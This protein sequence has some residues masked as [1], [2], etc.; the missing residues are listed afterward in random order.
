MT[1]ALPRNVRPPAAVIATV[2]TA[3]TAILSSTAVAATPVM[4]ADS[5]A[6]SPDG[7]TLVFAWRGDLWSV[8]SA[9]GQARPL[10]RHTAE[11]RDPAFSPDG[12]QLAFIS[13]RTGSAQVHLMPV[14]GGEPRQLTHHTEGHRAPVWT[15]DGTGLLVSGTRDHHWRGAERF[16]LLDAARR[17]A[18]KVL[19]DDYGADASFNKDGTKVLF[20]REGHR[21]WR[22][23]YVGSQACQVWLFDRTTGTFKAVL[24][25]D[26]DCRR[27]LWK[28]DGNGFWY[29]GSP[30]G[31]AANLWEHDL[32]T[33]QEKRL[34]DFA[35]DGVTFP[36]VSA[37]GGT[38]VFRRLFDLWR[39][40][41]GKDAAPVKLA[42]HVDDDSAGRPAV[43][44]RTLTQAD[45]F[46][47]TPDGLEV[48]I[49]AGGDLWVMDGELREPRRVTTGAGTESDPVF[50]ADGGAVLFVSDE[51]GRSDIF[52]A[53]RA[54]PAKPW[55]LNERFVVRRLTDDDEVERDLRL[56]PDGATVAFVKGRG[57]LWLMGPDGKAPRPLRRHWSAPEFDWSPDG[58]WIAFA[59]YDDDFNRDVWI[60]PV[61]GSRPPVNVSR[62]PNVEGE[63]VWSPDGRM[64]AFTGRRD[65][66]EVD[67]HYVFLRAEDDRRTA[68]DRAVQKA[69]EKFRKP[70]SPKAGGMTGTGTSSEDDRDAHDRRVGEVDGPGPKTKGR[71]RPDP[72]AMP[73]ADPKADPAAAGEP[74]SVPGPRAK[75]PAEVRI[76]FDGIHERVRRV[77]LPDS[78]ESG[79]VWMPDGKR[80]AFLTT[81]G[82]QRGLYT[83][84]P[85]EDVKP[86]PLAPTATGSSAIRTDNGLAWLVGGVPT[87][88]SATGTGRPLAFRALQSLDPAERHAAAFDT[89]WRIM[90]DNW[91]DERMGNT[92]W[93][94]VRRKYAPAAATADVGQLSTVVNMM[95]GELNGS[96]LGFT[97]GS[98]DPDAPTA[99]AASEPGWREVT[100]HLGVRFDPGFAGPGLRVRDVLPRGPADA[101]AA[102]LAPGETILEIDG[103]PV[104]PDTDLSAVLT[105]PPARDVRLKVR[106]A[107]PAVPPAAPAPAPAD[108]A[109]VPAA[110]ADPAERVVT[111]RPISWTEA[112]SLL[113]E[114]WMADNRAAV[115][116]LSGGRLG[117]LHIAGMNMPSFRRFEQELYAVG[118]GKEGLLID[119][120]ENGGGFT[121]DHLLT[122]LTQPVH[123][124]TVPRGGGVG[125]PQDR[126][127]YATWNRPI[128]VLC[129]QNSF[130]NAE[131]FSHAVKTLGRGRL[132][133]VP[134][135][136]GVISTGAARVTDVGMIRLPFRG[137]Y[138]VADGEDMELH[139]AVPHFVM[140]PAP[141]DMPAGRDAQ[142][143]RAVGVLL[144]DVAKDASR[145]RPAFRKATER[146]LPGAGK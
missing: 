23:G 129:N 93:G 70:G 43:L 28:P 17:S 44:R 32:R 3:L 126:K 99:G 87:V 66:D 86:K 73:G 106:A 140:W 108:G 31:Q 2:A 51:G 101:P 115:D 36:A 78:A 145:P 88:M 116:R 29:V 79:L 120:R 137:W 63:P 27:P 124:L 42:I 60:L 13:T 122:A 38:I 114:K 9:G 91:Y 24:Q 113:Y 96:H 14:A 138:G 67:V 62:S 26:T 21:W 56:S 57:D 142:L 118:F 109:A 34:T 39:F 18:E 58:R 20:T 90:R 16:L 107:A 89:A 119:V 7:A 54:D 121:A 41:P 141:G 45:G 111:L 95:L 131:I 40:R 128:T 144:E 76:D 64:L 146:P 127:V 77:S 68:R 53:E 81:V 104:G 98:R 1:H 83:I 102:K 136:G 84:E 72:A 117:Y 105:G 12:R 50:T 135:A 46:A 123:A 69:M 59:Q 132:V 103:A 8:P 4:L 85:P 125:Y 35:D 110:P 80:L 52:R 15:P 92:D 139:G 37:D 47:L 75:R 71:P 6:L 49:T 19:F 112:R 33:G 134:T 74:K 55:F 10:T 130:S 22:K 94:A 143:E 133:G 65:G 25:R 48:A 11:D 5:P 82:G 100:G 30:A 97:A 61:D